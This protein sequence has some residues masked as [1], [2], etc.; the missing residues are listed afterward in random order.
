[1]PKSKSM[2]LAIRGHETRGAEVIALLEM[3]GG[4]NNSNLYGDL[5]G[6]Y[7]FISNFN[8]IDAGSLSE[9]VNSK[10]YLLN[11]YLLY[12]LEEF[13]KSSHSKLEIK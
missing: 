2:K 1:M 7:Y 4:I 12:S 3:F 13:E 10:Q 5:N 6:I 11:Q 9:D 8:D